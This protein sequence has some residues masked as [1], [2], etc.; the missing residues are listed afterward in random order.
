MRRSTLTLLTAVAMAAAVGCSSP[1]AASEGNPEVRELQDRV[2]ELTAAVEELEYQNRE[3][4]A[5]VAELD[6]RRRELESRNA[7]LARRLSPEDRVVDL[8]NPNFPPAVGGEPGWEYHRT[9]TADLDGDGQE[10]RVSVTT[11]A[12]WMPDEGEFAWDDGHPW[13]VY[14]EEPDGTRTYLFSNWVQL[15]QLEVILDREGPGLFIVYKRGGGMVVY[16]ATYEGPGQFR[17]VL[18]FEIPLSDHAT[19]A[20]PEMFS[21]D[22]EV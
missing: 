13:H 19:W 9:L 14:V 2:A 5:Q 16:R 12:V 6:A 7:D 10:E 8:V 20:N 22:P 11:N 4:E 15:G 18:A 3:L 1:P 21:R 17:T